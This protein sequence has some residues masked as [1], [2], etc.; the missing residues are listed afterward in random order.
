MAKT[1]KAATP[2]STTV[3]A[4][5]SDGF[6]E[7][8][9]L[10]EEMREICDNTPEN[11]QSSSKYE[12]REAAADALENLSEPDVPESV[13]DIAVNFSI[14]PHK[15]SYVSRSDRRHEAIQY[16][17]AAI[18]V[19]N[20]NVEAWREAEKELV[21]ADPDKTDPRISDAEELIE[22]VQEAIDEGEAVEFPGMY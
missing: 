4:A 10:G 19:L 14:M 16:L 5:I 13:A 21:A 20:E 9:T 2:I 6:S 18:D 1:K 3:G 17:Q 7:L 8:L 15:R 12:E 11:L 22:E